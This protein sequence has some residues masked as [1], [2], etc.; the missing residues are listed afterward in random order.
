MS[1]LTRKP[2]S[3]RGPQRGGWP[4]RTAKSQTPSSPVSIHR[5][6]LLTWSTRMSPQA[7][8]PG[9]VPGLWSKTASPGRYLLCGSHVRPCES[10]P[11]QGRH[12]HAGLPGSDRVALQMRQRAPIHPNQLPSLLL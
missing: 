8:V 6:A 1:P 3:S 10:R 7:W 12:P 4:E 2:G 5:V 11:K 9:R